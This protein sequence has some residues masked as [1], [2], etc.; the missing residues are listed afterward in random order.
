MLE[1]RCPPETYM[2]E[3]I[4]E[5]DERF[6]QWREEILA[7]TSSSID[8]L[9]IKGIE[10][11][12]QGMGLPVSD[13]RVIRPE[14]WEGSPLQGFEREYIGEE[15]DRNSSLLGMTY[16]NID[17]SLIFRDDFLEETNGVAFTENIIVHELAH[18]AALPCDVVPYKLGERV[19]Y[20]QVRWGKRIVD[21]QFY[22]EF[23]DEGFAEWI[24][25]RYLVGQNKPN[26]LAGVKDEWIE[27]EE[28]LLLRSLY[29][30]CDSRH[31]DKKTYSV[32]D[33]SDIVY[34]NSALTATAMDLLV[35]ADPEIETA[36]FDCFIGLKGNREFARLVNKIKP[37]LYWQLFKLE[38][39]KDQ[40]TEGLRIVSSI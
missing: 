7:A 38:Q 30:Y 39:T 28:G 13:Y 17:I 11:F 23:Y 19:V 4:N 25:G 9:D 5:A 3:R 22:G 10:D 29:T 15:D 40:F 27:L 18:N 34:R 32:V 8:G 1:F 31:T 26:G 16:P 12:M 14:H 36:I 24:A 33:D 35:D 20:S 6:T 2:P 37:G 21:R